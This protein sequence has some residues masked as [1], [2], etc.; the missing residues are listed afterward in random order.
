MKPDIR[1][2]TLSTLSPVHIGCGEDFEPGNFVIHDGLLH[3]LDVETLAAELSEEE[4]KQLGDLANDANPIGRIQAFFAKKAERLA[5]V[6]NHQVPVVTGIAREY[7]QKMGRAVQPGNA[8]AANIFNQFNI[9]RTVWRTI[10]NAAYLPG[11]SLKGSIR[12]AWLNHVNN[13]QALPQR[14]EKNNELQQRLLGYSFKAKELH[15]DPFRLLAIADAQGE[16]EAPLTRILYAIS[17]KKKPSQ[18]QP[19]A[20][21]VYREAIAEAQPAA[22]MGEMRFLPRKE[23]LA[24]DITWAALCDACNRFYGE[25]LGAELRDNFLGAKLEKGWQQLMTGLLAN[26]LDALIRARQGF[27]LRVGRHSGA[28]SVTLD[29]VRSITIRFPGVKKG[30]GPTSEKRSETTEKRFATNDKA[31]ENG[32]LPFGWIWV[33]A[34]E[35][36]Y[37]AV[38]DSLRQKLAAYSQKMREDHRERLAANENRRVELRHKAAEHAAQQQAAQAEAARRAREDAEKAAEEAARKA[39]MT[40]AMREIAEFCDDFRQKSEALRGGKE[41]P[42]AVYHGKARAFVQKA[43]DAA[44]WSAAEKTAAADAVAEWLPKVVRVDK[45]Q[46]KKMKLNALR[47]S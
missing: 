40:P 9:E 36:Q 14:N 34:S 3:A 6:S 16:D 20:I 44:D 15:K 42:N 22:F 23:N 17:K 19:S 35:G 26:E 27:L 38:H 13:G 1:K 2:L 28:E 11:S 4:R 33:D 31:N 18:F 7:A 12:T 29:G 30:E 41:N 32:L 24:K 25:K 8:G 21:T 39:A 43:L 10:D 47:G 45:D 5:T 46:L 37:C